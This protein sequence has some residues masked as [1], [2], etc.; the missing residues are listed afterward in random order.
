MI[1]ARKTT[2]RGR[3]F[4]KLLLAVLV[5]H[6]PAWAGGVIEIAVGVAEFQL[7][8]HYAPP[9]SRRRRWAI[10]ARAMMSASRE[11]V[12]TAS[13]TFSKLGPEALTEVT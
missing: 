4:T 5:T 9:R 3:L 7:V 10:S 2:Q 6:V 1:A 12:M 13:S 8:L 11:R